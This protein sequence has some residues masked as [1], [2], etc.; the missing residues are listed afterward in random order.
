[1]NHQNNTK[2]NN[3]HQQ[4]IHPKQKQNSTTRNSQAIQKTKWG[5]FIYFGTDIRVITKLFKIYKKV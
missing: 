2:D 5:T 4:I 1:M 3:Y